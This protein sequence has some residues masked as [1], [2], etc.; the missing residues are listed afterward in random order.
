MLMSAIIANMQPND[1]ANS[2]Q[3]ELVP[4]TDRLAERLHTVYMNVAR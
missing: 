3:H 1:N 4:V 2:C